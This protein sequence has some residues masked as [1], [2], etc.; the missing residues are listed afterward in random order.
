MPH[1][2]LDKCIEAGGTPVLLPPNADDLSALERVDGLLLVGGA[3]IDPA[4]YSATPG[5]H[6]DTPRTSRDASELA[7]YKRARELN[8]PVLGICRGL[9]VMAVAHGG[10]L[11][12]H[13]PDQVGTLH[14]DVPGTFNEHRAHFSQGSLIAQILETTDTVVNSSHHQAVADAG[15][16]TATGWA[17]D[18]SI[19]VCEDPSEPFILGVQWHPEVMNDLR[20]FSAFVAAC[21]RN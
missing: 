13:L 16:L 9:Q 3:D 17:S 21:R 8:L 4:R 10:R 12:Q 18:E 14:R 2:Y 19:E 5:P 11:E 15:T 1:E 6:T 7:L 20:I